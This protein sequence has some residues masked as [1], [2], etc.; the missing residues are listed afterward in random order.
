[1]SDRERA[2]ALKD[3]YAETFEGGSMAYGHEGKTLDLA[4]LVGEDVSVA[5]L[6][7]RHAQPTPPGYSPPG[8]VVTSDEL[9]IVALERNDIFKHVAVATARGGDVPVPEPEPDHA[10]QGG[11]EPPA[12]EPPAEVNPDSHNRDELVALALDEDVLTDEHGT[13]LDFDE[14]G[15]TK[16]EL[17]DAINH[18]RAARAAG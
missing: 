14:G 15:S 16:A 6:I 8:Y 1:M 5:E 9:V 12:G 2:F 11:G 4:R 18:E 7:D 17:A 10:Q 13:E 3:A